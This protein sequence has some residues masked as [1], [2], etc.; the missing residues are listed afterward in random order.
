[1]ARHA[2]GLTPSELQR[3]TPPEARLV[4]KLV[5]ERLETEAEERVEHTKAIMRVIARKPSL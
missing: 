5:V 4:R 1:M 2:P 3:M